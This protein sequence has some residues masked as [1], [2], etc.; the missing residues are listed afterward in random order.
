MSKDSLSQDCRRN[1]SFSATYYLLNMEKF[2]LL[3]M[4]AKERTYAWYVWGLV[5]AQ[6]AVQ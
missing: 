1:G 4:N 6:Q 3:K 5:Y 2:F